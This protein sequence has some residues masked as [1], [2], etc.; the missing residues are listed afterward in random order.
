MSR[1]TPWLS[2]IQGQTAFELFKS[3]ISW[4]WLWRW[5]TR[6]ISLTPSQLCWSARALKRSDY[7]L[8]SSLR[9]PVRH[10]CNG[11]VIELTTSYVCT[12]INFYA[13]FMCTVNAF[14]R[15]CRVAQWY[16]YNLLSL[17]ASLG[18]SLP[19][20]AAAQ[21]PTRALLWYFHVIILE[22]PQYI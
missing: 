2:L 22:M 19:A 1:S 20:A 14:R 10:A 7:Y 17:F 6:I 11:L 5:C 12:G 21:F 8:H 13:S 16:Q 18:L 4:L 9:T 15:H 3:Q